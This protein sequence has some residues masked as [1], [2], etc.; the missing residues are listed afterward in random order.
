MLTAVSGGAGA[1]RT[2]GRSLAANSRGNA[3]LSVSCVLDQILAG[4][5]WAVQLRRQVKYKGSL[6]RLCGW[7]ASGTR[8]R[9]RCRIRPAS[10]ARAH[11][12]RPQPPH[13]SLHPAYIALCVGGW[14][15]GHRH[16]LSLSLRLSLFLSLS[17]SLSLSSSFSMAAAR[18]A[19]LL[20]N[21][22][23]STDNKS[24]RL[25]LERW[26]PLAAAGHKG[27]GGTLSTD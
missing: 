24:Q 27:K 13:Q 11:D 26:E 17:L 16:A 18:A 19:T 6:R 12:V 2:G 3:E 25:A 14:R 4:A 21:T 22:T 20:F 10:N 8:G 5:G 23:T 1:G 7:T 15:G 9:R